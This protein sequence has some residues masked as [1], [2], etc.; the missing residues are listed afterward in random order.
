[1]K[2]HKPN[3]PQIPDHPYK[4]LTVEGSD[5]GKKIHFL[6]YITYIINKN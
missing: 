1:M 6:T 3:W 5:S 2:D 4:I